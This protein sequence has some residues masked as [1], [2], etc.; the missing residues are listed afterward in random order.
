MHLTQEVLVN[1][2]CSGGSS[3]PTEV[4][5]LKKRNI[6]V[7]HWK[8]TTTNWK[9]SLKLLLLQLHEKLPKN[10]ISIILWSFGIWSKLER[11]KGSISGCLLSWPEKIK[12]S[13]WSVIF[14]YSMQQQ[15]TISQSDCDVGWKVDFIQQPAMTSSVATL[16]GISKALPRAKLAPKKCHGHWCSAAVLIHESILNPSKIIASETYAQQINEM[17]RKLQWLQLALAN[18]MG[19]VLHD[20]TWTHFAQLMLQKLNKL[21]YKVLL[22]VSYSPDLLPTDYQFF[23]LLNNFCREKA[24]TISRRQKMLSKSS[25]NPEAQIFTLQK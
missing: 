21:A 22:H 7:G 11:W 1:I 10:S 9:Q 16:R 3:F 23:K 14:S 20:N 24:S 5:V 25:S 17:Q 4:R 6:V 19:P 13:F 15:W 12:T 18:R 8:M 2:Q